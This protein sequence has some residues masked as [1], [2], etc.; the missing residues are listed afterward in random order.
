MAI[1]INWSSTSGKVDKTGT[2]SSNGFG[3]GNLTTNTG[4]DFPGLLETHLP[5]NNWITDSMTSINNNLAI[6]E[7]QLR[8]AIGSNL[9]TMTQQIEEF[10]TNYNQFAVEYGSRLDSYDAAQWYGVSLNTN[11]MVTGISL[12]SVNGTSGHDSYFKVAADKFIVGRSYDED[13]EV[14]GDSSYATMWDYVTDTPIPAF[15][16][17]WNNEI[18]SY[19]LAFNGRVSFKNL[20]GENG[21]TI[22]DGGRLSTNFIDVGQPLGEAANINK[23]IGAFGSDSAA[24]AFISAN[25]LIVTDGDSYYNTST[26]VTMFRSG[27]SWVSTKG[28]D[29]EDGEDGATGPRGYTGSTGARGTMSLVVDVIVSGSTV[30]Y[31]RFGDGSWTD[32]GSRDDLDTNDDYSNFFSYLIYQRAY[33]YGKD[34]DNIKYNVYT[35]TS[36]TSIVGTREAVHNG[37]EWMINVVAQFHG[38]VIVDGTLDVNRVKAGEIVADSVSSD[39]IYTNNLNADNITSGSLTKIESGIFLYGEVPP[40][41]FST[42]DNYPELMGSFTVGTYKTVLIVIT[43]QCKLSNNTFNEHDDFGISVRAKVN[44]TTLGY[45]YSITEGYAATNTSGALLI[46]LRTFNYYN[47]SLSLYVSAGQEQLGVNNIILK[48]SAIISKDVW[49]S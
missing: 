30:S 6:T 2:I 46:S 4:V 37:S 27:S 9:Q 8:D 22:I 49:D 44:G 12:G 5:Q 36:S 31:Y 13:E 26:L 19:D 3:G 43:Y 41:T 35:S 45:D 10:G 14:T 33:D 20:T 29:G 39:W 38:D 47:G 28:E 11:G 42:F 16:I 18:N 34:G 23:H 24:D 21:E 17:E 25:E 15:A 48:Y 1:E 32:P 40:G 7:S